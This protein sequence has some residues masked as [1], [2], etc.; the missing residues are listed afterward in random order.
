MA[1][2]WGN[3]IYV[4]GPWWE[5][6]REVGVFSFMWLEDIF[7]TDVGLEEGQLTLSCCLPSRHAASL[8][9]AGHPG[10]LLSRGPSGAGE[11]P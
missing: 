9:V 2:L 1:F 11:S 10:V 5:K 4:W 6:P 3:V 7:G 8:S